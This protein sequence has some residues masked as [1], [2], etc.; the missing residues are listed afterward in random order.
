M[1]ESDLFRITRID[2]G[3]VY[4]RHLGRHSESGINV[5][6]LVAVY[7]VYYSVFS[8]AS[9]A[10]S[11]LIPNLQLIDQGLTLFVLSAPW[12]VIL[13]I[14][15]PAWPFVLSILSAVALSIAN[16]L[17]PLPWWLAGLLLPVWHQLQQLSH[18]WYTVSRDMSRYQERYPKGA[19]LVVMLAVFELPILLNYFLEGDTER[20]V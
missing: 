20:E 1:S 13:F 4:R 7:G 19:R 8:L 3:E 15:V 2:F 12:L 6:H 18:R 5:L 17:A 14:N 9:A 16:V 11:G 10:V